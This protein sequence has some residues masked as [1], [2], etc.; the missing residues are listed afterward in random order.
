LPYSS[1]HIDVIISEGGADPWRLTCVYGEAQI[2]ERHKTW[3]MIKSIKQNSSLPWVCI[4]DFNEVLHRSVVVQERSYAQI[5]GFW[6][7]VD[8]CGLSD[9]GYESRSWT[10]EKKVVG[11]SYCRVRLDRALATPEWSPRFPSAK[12]RHLIS[13]ASDHCPIAM[14]WERPQAKKRKNGRFHYETMWERHET[15]SDML[16]ST[17]QDENV[18]TNVDQLKSKLMNVSCKLASWGKNTFGHV[19]KELRMLQEE[20]EGMQADPCRLG[21]SHRELKVVERIMELN[22]REELMWKQR[23]R[24]QCLATGDKNTRFFHFRASR[25]C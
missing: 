3:D 25:R 19:Q 8:V 11:G 5:A 14:E 9:L 17:W 21:P 23:A 16:A 15:F 6:E 10:Y 20:L 22:H 13:A 7:M 1:Y 18:A 2:S 24:L 4:G 12:V